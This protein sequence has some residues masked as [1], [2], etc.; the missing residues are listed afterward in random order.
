MRLKQLELSGFKSFAKKTVFLF[1]SPIMA[2]VGPNGSGKSNCA[3]AFRWVLGERS[4]KS[5]RGGRGE[6]LIF[7]GGGATMKMNRAVVS[8]TFANHDRK[9]NVDFDEVIITREVYRDGTNVY[10]INGSQVRFRDIIELLAAVSLGSSDHYIVNQGDADRILGANEKER[11]V[12][13]ED[14]LGL[15]I[16]QWKIEESEKKLE[17]TGENLKQV[18]SLRREL[19][20]QLK[21]LKKQMEKIEQADKLRL[22]LKQF[23]FEYLQREENYLKQETAL[24]KQAQEVP[25]QELAKI[26][27]TLAHDGNR[28]GAETSK[29]LSDKLARIDQDLRENAHHRDEL[30]R[31][32]GRLEGRLE[33]KQVN[34][35]TAEREEARDFSYQEVTNFTQNLTAQL[36]QAERLFDINSVKNFLGRIKESIKHFLKRGHSREGDEKA[37]QE[38]EQIQADKN[39]VEVKLTQLCEQ[40]EV[41]RGDKEKVNKQI[42]AELTQAR[43]A[44]REVYELRARRT[45]QIARLAT[46]TARE[47]KLAIEGEN[48][49]RE[50][51]EAKVLVDQEILRYRDLA[52]NL[53]PDTDR[54][55]QEDRR[56][57][58]ERIK[59]R[60]EDMG[61][62]TGDTTKEYQVTSERDAFLMK[63][64]IDLDASAKSLAQIIKDLQLKIDQDFRDGLVKIN[65]YFQEFFVLMFG[66]GT[67]G[68]S[69]IKEKPW[70]IVVDDSAEDLD[71]ETRLRL[72][73]EDSAV[74]KEGIEIKVNLPRKK[75]HGLQMLSGGERALTSIALIFAMSQVNPPPFLILDET[76][77]ALDEANSRKYSEMVS[78]LA[79]HSQLILITHNRETM[80]R[81]NVIDGVTMSSD[82]V[83]KLLS[84]KFDEAASYAK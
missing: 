41:W 57:K 38:L 61:V 36:E 82:G 74:A 33:I 45:E 59:I 79:N 71:E 73:T 65:H 72:L 77:A 54:T 32:L 4:M 28:S 34:L 39:K 62:E 22:E 14:A 2:I 49:E 6:D 52:L 75:I 60:L 8:L 80:S 64:V 5:L 3:E 83:S 26:D 67:A 69:L 70:R 10:L 27:K 15:R 50:L 29:E 21:F 11:R 84:I 7:N 63:E 42:A 20:P 13:I 37:K 19:A 66:G 12:M 23:Y 35:V 25:T 55:A 81:A 31:Q 47:E 16:Y 40:E 17:K 78:N 1:D 18:E 58:I 48:F 68:V 24:I 43:E 46:L 56:R 9:F 53:V 51:N 44:E 76:D 30:G